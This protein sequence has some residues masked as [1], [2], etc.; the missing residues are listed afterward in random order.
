MKVSTIFT[1]G[2]LAQVW[3]PGRVLKSRE[4][5]ISVPAGLKTYMSWIFNSRLGLVIVTARVCAI[6]YLEG[7]VLLIIC[8]ATSTDELVCEIQ[9]EKGL[10][11]VYTSRVCKVISDLAVHTN[12]HDE[13]DFLLGWSMP[14]FAV[15]ISQWGAEGC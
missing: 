2:D 8:L 11:A 1:K 14:E 12:I 5:L 13:L 4:I 15:D 3:P 6:E 9:I 7:L 10:R